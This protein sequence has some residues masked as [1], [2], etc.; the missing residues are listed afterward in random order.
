M[1]F[2]KDDLQGLPQDLRNEIISHDEELD[3]ATSV[4]GKLDEIANQ[5]GFTSY[6][7]VV[8]KIATHS[9]K[10]EELLKKAKI[11]TPYQSEKDEISDILEDLIPLNTM[12]KEN[13]DSIVEN[14]PQQFFDNESLR[15][16]VMS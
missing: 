5:F 1:F 3:F 6:L 12:I 15:G 14:V 10:L 4:V 8:A 16:Y 7:D 9:K 13:Q 2:E 11:E